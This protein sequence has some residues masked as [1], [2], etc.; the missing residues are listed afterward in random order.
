MLDEL[1]TGGAPGYLVAAKT[2]LAGATV[3]DTDDLLQEAIVM[4]QVGNHPNLVSVVGAITSGA[5]IVLIL[6]YCEHG[7]FQDLLKKSAADNNNTSTQSSFPF[8]HI[9]NIETTV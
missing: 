8:P 2:V 9:R 7:S 1:A 6:S 5:P 4:S 3:Q